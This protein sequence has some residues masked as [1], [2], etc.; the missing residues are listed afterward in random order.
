[1]LP[2]VLLECNW[3]F[4][5]LLVAGAAVARTDRLAAVTDHSREPRVHQE[6]IPDCW[7]RGNRATRSRSTRRP[8][9]R[10][11]FRRWMYFRWLASRRWTAS[12]PGSESE[13]E[14]K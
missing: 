6:E 1:M 7:S 10:A 5:D 3:L 11:V 4:L 9:A 8:W 2:Q 14:S 13:T 12:K